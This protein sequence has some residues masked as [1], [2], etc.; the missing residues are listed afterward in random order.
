[1]HLERQLKAQ[2]QHHPPQLWFPYT[3][4]HYFTDMDKHSTT[5]QTSLKT[6]KKNLTS[7]PTDEITL[8]KLGAT[9]TMEF[10][11]FV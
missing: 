11:L 2:Q 3:L 6:Q 7:F 8:Q 4:K 10:N 5:Q 1:M 9:A